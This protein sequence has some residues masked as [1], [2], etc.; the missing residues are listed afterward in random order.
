MLALMKIK[1]G[2]SNPRVTLAACH[3]ASEMLN[4][5]NYAMTALLFREGPL[6]PLS[7]GRVLGSW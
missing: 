6:A 5:L 2:Q 3:R 7:K 4:I 1:A